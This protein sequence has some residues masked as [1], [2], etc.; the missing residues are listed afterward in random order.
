MPA[1]V[2][3]F[4]CL[5]T[6]IYVFLVCFCDFSFAIV[7]FVIDK[8]LNLLLP[9]AGFPLLQHIQQTHDPS[10]AMLQ[11]IGARLISLDRSFRARLWKAHY[12]GNRCNTF[13]RAPRRTRGDRK[14]PD[15]RQCWMASRSRQLRKGQTRIAIL[16]R[17]RKSASSS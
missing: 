11:A 7:I 1:S 8:C 16:N 17:C 4:A 13:K 14:R 6:A 12:F 3:C 5:C 10:W 9:L 2:C 15:C